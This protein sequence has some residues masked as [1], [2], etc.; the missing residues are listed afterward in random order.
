MSPSTK[1][2]INKLLRLVW[3]EFPIAWPPAD[4][5]SNNFRSLCE[6]QSS[7][8]QASIQGSPQLI[9]FLSLSQ[10]LHWM[11][12]LTRLS[13]SFSLLSKIWFG[14]Y[15]TFA[16][17][18]VLN[19]PFSTLGV[20]LMRL[21]MWQWSSHSHSHLKTESV[22]NSGINDFLCKLA[23]LYL[24]INF[25]ICLVIFFTI[26]GK[27][28]YQPVGKIISLLRSVCSKNICYDPNHK[29]L[30]LYNRGSV[31]TLPPLSSSIFSPIQSL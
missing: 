11:L 28:T 10:F 24:S 2:N 16:F 4:T 9:D 12:L 19:S 1:H 20:G 25:F 31:V 8:G 7:K 14:Y 13:A 23:F 5:A 22:I 21:T 3:D 6:D 17:T 26:T 15:S 30:H 27:H 18:L 29:G